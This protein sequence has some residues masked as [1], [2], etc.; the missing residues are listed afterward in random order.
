MRNILH[1]TTEREQN[2]FKCECNNLVFVVT[3]LQILLPRCIS[4]TLHFSHF[5]W[6]SCSVNYL[7]Y[8]LPPLSEFPLLPPPNSMGQPTNLYSDFQIILLLSL[9]WGQRSNPDDERPSCGRCDLR[10]SCNCSFD[11][12]TRVPMVTDHALSLDLS[13]NNITVVTDDDLTGHRQLRVL[14]LHGGYGHKWHLSAHPKL[15]IVSH[16]T[17]TINIW[18][19]SGH[20]FCCTQSQEWTSELHFLSQCGKK[21]FSIGENGNKDNKNCKKGHFVTRMF[22]LE[23]RAKLTTSTFTRSGTSKH[24]I[25]WL[26]YWGAS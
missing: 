26:M 24:L 9:C 10:L 7:I 4:F 1:S 11:G 21:R 19:T 13:Y 25:T 2:V 16:C 17:I 3:V 15:W 18:V 20:G 22:V 23:M 12:F 5:L 6:P 8:L 14:S